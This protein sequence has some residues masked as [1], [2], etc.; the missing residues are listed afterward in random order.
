M[1]PFYRLCWTIVRTYLKLFCKL[2]IIGAENIPQTGGVILASNHIAGVDPPIVAVSVC[3]EVYF[4]AKRELFKNFILGNLI[5]H[6]NAFP[7]DRSIL[8]QQAL[9]TAEKALRNGFGLIIFPEGTRSLNGELKKG[10]PGVGLLARRTIVPVI[11][12]YIENS[13]GFYKLIFSRKRLK[14]VFGK[15]IS[16]EWIAQIP[17]DNTGYRLIAEEIMVKIADLGGK[18][19]W[20]QAKPETYKRQD[21]P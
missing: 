18:K 13:R 11:P 17:D 21:Q 16:Q 5:T 1:K 12:T 2:K 14:I 9:Q 7:V 19:V 8:D 20:K 10:K 15:P 4:L 3:R 6:L